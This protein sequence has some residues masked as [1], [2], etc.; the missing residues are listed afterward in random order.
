[1]PEYKLE[2]LEPT[3][4]RLLHRRIIQAADD[5]EA[6]RRADEF[7]DGVAAD[8]DVVLGRYVLY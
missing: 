3:D 4:E 5:D 8:P 1:M 6:I 2:V 7:Y